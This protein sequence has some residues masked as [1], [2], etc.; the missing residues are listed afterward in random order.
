MTDILLNNERNVIVYDASYIPQ[1]TEL[2]KQAGKY[3]CQLINGLEMLI[4]QAWEQAK[5]F[6]GKQFFSEELREE[7]I[8]AVYEYYNSIDQ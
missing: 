2:L 3:N 1:E 4:E 8:K 6:T 7:V 5:L